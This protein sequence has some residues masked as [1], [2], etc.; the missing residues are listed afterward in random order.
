MIT[1]HIMEKPRLAFI[2]F[3]KGKTDKIGRTMKKNSIKTKTFLIPH[4]R[5]NFFRHSR[6][7]LSSWEAAYIRKTNR[8]IST[9]TQELIRQT[10]NEDTEKKSWLQYQTW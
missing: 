7:L 2:P 5:H 1:L 8:S 4:K 10:K 9:K 3:I 6:C